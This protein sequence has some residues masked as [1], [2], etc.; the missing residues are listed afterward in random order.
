MYLPTVIPIQLIEHYSEYVVEV[1]VLDLSTASSFLIEAQ[2]LKPER[3]I[4]RIVLEALF[5]EL[6]RF[7]YLTFSLLIFGCLEVHWS[8]GLTLLQEIS[9][10]FS[11]LF[12][13]TTS[14]LK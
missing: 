1:L 2:I 8:V 9:K 7:L 13:L 12:S 6:E 10:C 3:P 5:T 14:T 11:G 4:L